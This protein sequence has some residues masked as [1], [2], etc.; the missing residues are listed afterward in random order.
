[1]GL[2]TGVGIYDLHRGLR[3]DCACAVFHRAGNA[4]GDVLGE[5]G[6]AKMDPAIS[7][8]VQMIL[9]GMLPLLSRSSRERGS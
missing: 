1:M 2:D 8:S 9:R 7:N 3:D 6:G 4:S 5:T